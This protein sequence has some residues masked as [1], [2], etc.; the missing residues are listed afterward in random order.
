MKTFV[1]FMSR[2]SHAGLADYWEMKHS[3]DDFTVSTEAF[4]IYWTAGFY[5]P[6]VVDTTGSASL[7]AFPFLMQ[8]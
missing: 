3:H 6:I 8:K 7:D 2:F 5:Y 4:I 1:G